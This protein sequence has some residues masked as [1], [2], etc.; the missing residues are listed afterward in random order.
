M[1]RR[2]TVRNKNSLALPLLAALYNTYKNVSFLLWFV[3]W[4][5]IV[6]R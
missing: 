4:C 3:V 5:V 1:L 6:T 2:F